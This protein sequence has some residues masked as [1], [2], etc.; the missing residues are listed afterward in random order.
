MNETI[1]AILQAHRA[2]TATPADT[3]ARTFARM[4]RKNV[5]GPPALGAGHS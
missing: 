5:I 4:W 2:G 1:A 3:V